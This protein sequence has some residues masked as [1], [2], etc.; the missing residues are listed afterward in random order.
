MCVAVTS[1]IA[2]TGS[3]TAASGVSAGRAD[4]P[5]EVFEQVAPATVQVLGVDRSGTGVIYDAD[6]GL[7]ITNAHVVAGQS[8]LQVRIED[9]EP[10]PVRLMGSDPCE[11]LAV[12]KLVS[13][14]KDLDEVKFGTSGDLGQGDEVTAIG[15]P[16]AAGDAGHQKPV[17]TSGVVQSPDVAEQGQLSGPNFPSAVQHSATLNPGNSG[18]PL[19]NSDAELVG[20]NSFSYTGSIEGQHYAISSDHAAP[21]VKELAAGKS[22]NNP[23]WGSLLAISDPDFPS[24]FPADDQ[25]SAD[26]LQQILRK[27]HVDGLYVSSVSSN[28][29]ASEAKL[30]EG[31]IITRLKD[32]AVGT[33]P[34]V[35]GILQ[36]AAPGEK[37]GVDG[38]FTSEGQFDDGTPYAF[39]DPW[40]VDMTLRK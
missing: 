4:D 3:V 35:C 26:A 11:D 27:A 6:N 2:L 17:L 14:Q 13:P 34:K 28:S 18:G 37:L 38:V 36:S 9:R 24:Y 29:P 16:A 23:G 31:D 8:A 19:L 22:K 7:I 30:A 12:V 32:T 5:K 25:E 20:I 15:Y 21:I 33:V 10:V 1:A 39:G 40:H